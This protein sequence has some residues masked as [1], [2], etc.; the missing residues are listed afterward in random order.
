MG[1]KSSASQGQEIRLAVPE[2]GV[3]MD[4]REFEVLTDVISHVAMAQV[5]P[6]LLMC[7]S[8]LLSAPAQPSPSSPLLLASTALGQACTF[9][10]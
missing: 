1:V 6:L 2:I 3:V 8:R 9:F 4:S 7:L 5:G 10:L